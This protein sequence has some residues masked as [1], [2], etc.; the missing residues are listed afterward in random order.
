MLTDDTKEAILESTMVWEALEAD[1]RW[2]YI[3]DL[4]DTERTN[5]GL[6]TDTVAVAVFWSEYTGRDWYEWDV[7]ELESVL[8]QDA[9]HRA[10]CHCFVATDDPEMTDP[11]CPVYHSNW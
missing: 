10:M 9:A 5:W 8:A 3:T 7:E 11:D 6:E 4:T 1:I 2:Q